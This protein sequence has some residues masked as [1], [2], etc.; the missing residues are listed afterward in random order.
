VVLLAGAVPAKA[1]GTCEGQWHFELSRPDPEAKEWLPKGSFCLADRLPKAIDVSLRYRAGGSA[2]MSGSPYKPADVM[3]AASG[4][5]K[6][7][8]EGKAS[9]LP[10]ENELDI[11]VPDGTA[12]ISGFARCSHSD[13]RKAD[14]TRSGMTIA[15][16][17]TGTRSSEASAALVAGPDET[18]AAVLRAC[19]TRAAEDLWNL[20]TQRFRA[21]IDQRAA[22]LRQSLPAA[23]LRQ[24]YGYRGP[25]AGFT[26]QVY[27]RQVL[28]DRPSIEN[29]CAD[30]AQWQV[31]KTAAKD[32]GSLTVIHRPDGTA[33]GLRFAKDGKTWLLDQITKT[34][35]KPG[36]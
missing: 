35:A 6:F 27:L 25:G 36:N 15:L 7:V 12:T 19:R 4:Q 29:P 23:E 13:P 10:E 22:S 33:F 9:G 18:V 11:E 32:G 20:L 30:A 34:V 1:A 28:Q 26:G 8:F 5:C 3:T 14:G 24:I 21:E 16:K 17:V 31:G 2:E